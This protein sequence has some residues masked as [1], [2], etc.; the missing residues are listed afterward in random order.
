MENICSGEPAMLIAGPVVCRES[1]G[2]RAKS[3][4]FLF[5]STMSCFQG[6]HWRVEGVTLI[7]WRIAQHISKRAELF[8]D[9]NHSKTVEETVKGP[10]VFIYGHCCPLV[11]TLIDYLW[12]LSVINLGG[13]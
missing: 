9:V 4:M 1:T 7:L 3:N 10:L 6:E 13:Y 2:A 8:F 11:C 5:G 12:G